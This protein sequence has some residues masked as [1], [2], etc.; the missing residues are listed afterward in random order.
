VTQQRLTAAQR[1][2]AV[3]R[4]FGPD[5]QGAGDVARELGVAPS[6]VYRWAQKGSTQSDS[7]ERLIAACQ[8]LLVTRGYGELTVAD[9]ARAA[10]VAPRTA[11][12]SFA[13]KEA[14]FAAAV[15]DAGQ[16]LVTTMTQEMISGGHLAAGE[17]DDPL[18]GL[19]AL[20]VAGLHG[21]RDHPSS[22]L[23]FADLGVPPADDVASPWHE[24]MVLACEPFIAQA[25]RNG[26]VLDGNA[27]EYARAVVAAARALNALVV[28]GASPAMVE[29]MMARLPR[30]LDER[31][32]DNQER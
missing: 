32:P 24:A 10:G 4:A 27:R 1:R 2:E 16:R 7:A 18:G 28:S 22:Y 19:S 11:F 17:S 30:L 6:T 29:T 8:Q 25:I 9:V 20:L 12:N 26:Q 3:S 21:T 5:G 23:L 15:E 13:T 31:M 14:L